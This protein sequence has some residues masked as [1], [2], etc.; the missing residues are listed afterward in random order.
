MSIL[1]IKISDLWYVYAS[2][3]LSLYLYK[4]FNNRVRARAL[5]A[6]ASAAN[7]IGSMEVIAVVKELVLPRNVTSENQPMETNSMYICM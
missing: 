4:L 7:L 3:I 5:T 1:C 2:L 6:L